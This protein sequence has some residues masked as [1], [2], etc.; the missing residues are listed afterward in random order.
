MRYFYS[1]LLGAAPTNPDF[2]DV[3]ANFEAGGAQFVIHAIPAE[4]AKN[5]GIKSPPTPREEY[6]LKLIF[7][8][9]VKDVEAEH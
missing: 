6:P 7:A 1:Q 5:I 3:W 8:I 2:K 4:I 9:G